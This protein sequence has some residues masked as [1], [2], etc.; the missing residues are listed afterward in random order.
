MRARRLTF[1]ARL[2]EL[3]DPYVTLL[4]IVLACFQVFQIPTVQ[5]A[6]FQRRR[7]KGWNSFRKLTSSRQTPP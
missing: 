1:F 2:H 7:K 5:K 3:L 6:R 4:S